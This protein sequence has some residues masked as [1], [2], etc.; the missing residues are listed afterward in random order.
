[1][2]I[3][4]KS[5]KTY[6]ANLHCHTTISDGAH[7]PEEIKAL[8][9]AQGYSIVAYTDHSRM[10]AHHDLTDE[11]F[12][13]IASVEM[14]INK[15]NSGGR[16]YHFNLY[17]TKAD[18]STQPPTP[19]DMSIK[20][21]DIDAINAYLAARV[22]EG[23][24]VSYNHPTWSMQTYAEYAPLR[25]LWAMEIFNN[26]C[27]TEGCYGYA[28]HVYDEMLRTGERP[29]CLATDDNHNRFAK[30]LP[31]ND[32][33]GGWVEVN[34]PDLAYESVMT[35]LAQGNF[36]STRGPK[37]HEISLN[38]DILTVKCSPAALIQVNTNTRGAYV[39]YGENLTQAQF[40]LEKHEY[41]R[42]TVRDSEGREAYSNAY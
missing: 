16:T 32:S 6:R 14:D 22:A 21:D 19:Q 13:A 37:L 1:M 8:Y 4:F 41:I 17:A 24:L 11:D 18:M 15:P 42:V 27:E 12:L 35:A 36:Y 10:V 39:Q 23:Y 7:T 26:G 33:F 25:H 40:K 20:Y 9:K 34:S 38:G 29:F 5:D 31:Q 28:P 30:N 2:K 3:L